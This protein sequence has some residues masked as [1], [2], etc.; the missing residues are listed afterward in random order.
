MPTSTKFVELYQGNNYSES[1][2]AQYAAMAN[3]A[4]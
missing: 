1:E 4:H 3:P 2:A